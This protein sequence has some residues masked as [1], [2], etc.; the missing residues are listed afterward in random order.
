MTR[1]G[2]KESMYNASVMT[3]FCEKFGFVY[4]EQ[5]CGSSSKGTLDQDYPRGLHERQRKPAL[6]KE[7]PCFVDG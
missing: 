1:R 6:K 3:R 7:Y 5:D 4:H 2:C